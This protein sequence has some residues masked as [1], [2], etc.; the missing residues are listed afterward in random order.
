MSPRRRRAAAVAVLVVLVVL[1]LGAACNRSDDP[2]TTPAPSDPPLELTTGE[3]ETALLSLS[4]AGEEKWEAEDDAAPSTV[5]IGGEVGPANID[6]TADAT[7]AFT[8]KEGTGYLSN[9][10]LTVADEATARAIMGAHDDGDARKR[11][12]QERNDG[13]RSV[14]KRTG[15]V[16]DLPSLGDESYSAKISA[17]VTDAEGE[18]TTRKIEYVAY[19]IRNV[20]AFVVT[21]DARAAVYALRQEAKVTRLVA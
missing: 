10:V 6:T 4:D 16:A 13:G 15:R 18:E 19:R 1:S 3:L 2:A 7:S 12:T 14:F 17:T 8:S 21:Q 9:T 11:W 20:I 5:L